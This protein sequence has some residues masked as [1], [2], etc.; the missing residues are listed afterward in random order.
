MGQL[1]YVTSR[2]SKDVLTRKPSNFPC[3]TRS[4]CGSNPSIIKGTS[5]EDKNVVPVS[6][7]FIRGVFPTIHTSDTPRTHC[8]L[9]NFRCDSSLKKIHLVKK[10]L[11]QLY[12]CSYARD[13]TDTTELPPCGN[14]LQ[15]MHVFM[16]QIR[17]KGT[18]ALEEIDFL[19]YLRLL[20]WDFHK[21][22][23]ITL[24][25][26]GC[27]PPIINGNSFQE[28]RILQLV[29]RLPLELVLHSHKCTMFLSA[30]GNIV[31]LCEWGTSCEGGAINCCVGEHSVNHGWLCTGKDM[32]KAPWFYIL[33][34][35]VRKA[36]FNSNKAT[37]CVSGTSLVLTH[38][39][40]HTHT[41]SWSSSL[42]YTAVF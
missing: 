20:A 18:L 22:S 37:K 28:R 15:S 38:Y 12:L 17:I 24:Y 23:H 14:G 13:F 16:R 7:V 41:T 25:I 4:K 6:H 21:A 33:Y 11:C 5:L 9:R 3:Y 36:H 31:H 2:D 26:S 30:L 34:E 1:L 10:V 35:I 40:M 42:Q 27:H 19:L 8:V 29:C 32:Y 39:K